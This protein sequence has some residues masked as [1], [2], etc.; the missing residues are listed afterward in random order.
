MRVKLPYG[1]GNVEIELP[2]DGVDVLWPQE[3]PPLPCEEE[4]FRRAVAEPLGTGS[5]QNLARGVQRA[6][7]VI[8]DWTRPTPNHLLVPWLLEEMARSSPPPRHV[9]I[10]VAAGTHE[11]PDGVIPEP[12]WHELPDYVEVVIHNAR[13]EASLQDVGRTTLGDIRLHKDYVT[14]DL[15]VAIG[16]IEPHFFA[17]FSGGGKAI[18]PGIAALPNILKLH[19]PEFIAHPQNTWFVRE[20]NPTHEAIVEAVQLCPPEF[21]VNVTLDREKRMTGIFTGHWLQAHEE[22]SEFCRRYN[23]VPGHKRYSVVITTNGGYPLDQNLYQ[24]VKGMSAAAR[25]T[26]RGGDILIA[27]ACHAG[28]PSEGN[29]ARLLFSHSHLDQLLESSRRSPAV[30]D[31]W[32]AQALASIL[33]QYRVHLYSQLD[34]NTVNQ[35]FLHPVSDLEQG[36]LELCQR[37]GD[38]ARLAVLPLGPLAVPL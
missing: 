11:P 20:G 7:I 38:G 14:A 4:A 27:S 24:T 5:L 9:T 19:S 15:R 23:S 8:S 32:E 34:A 37:H 29:F 18:L 16:F 31:Q 17:G 13:D 22:G 26:A 25:I 36:V 2:K 1:H 10:L 3:A 28:I 21:L 30:L 35:C 12:W 33:A 6:C